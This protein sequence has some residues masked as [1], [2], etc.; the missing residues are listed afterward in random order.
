L[1][2]RPPRYFI[3]LVPPI[4]FLALFGL[5]ELLFFDI[6]RMKKNRVFCVPYTGWLIL[7]FFLARKYI[8]IKPLVVCA[9]IGIFL[10][11]AGSVLGYL[12]RF[13]GKEYVRRAGLYVVL[14]IV[15]LFFSQ[16]FALY[17]NW[18]HKPEYRE[19]TI[20]REV[21][22]MVK[23]GTIVGLW[24]PMVCMENDNRALCI[25][26]RWF[27][28]NHPY[29][30]YHFT[31]LFLWRGNRDAELKLIKGPL[32]VKFLKNRLKL[33]KGFRIK[34]SWALLY[35]VIPEQENDNRNGKKEG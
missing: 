11:F 16:N 27:N 3:S 15:S 34:G 19:I 31:H 35:K 13:G 6:G 21:G 1:R 25:A 10:I 9:G 22:R 8:H 5:R 33:I 26:S 32:G 24:A 18:W 7:T 30:K 28:D 20:S 17:Y 23:H 4:I 2:Y 14:M 12:R 29:E